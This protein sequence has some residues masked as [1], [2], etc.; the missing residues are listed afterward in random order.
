MRSCSSAR[1]P[2]VAISGS[3][4]R[5]IPSSLHAALCRPCSRYQDSSFFKKTLSPVWARYHPSALI[6][7]RGAWA[8][9]CAYKRQ[10]ICWALYLYHPRFRYHSQRASLLPSYRTRARAV[11][12]CNRSCFVLRYAQSTKS[13]HCRRFSHNLEYCFDYRFDY[14]FG[15]R[16]G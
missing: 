1:W 15:H 4:R 2:Y 11:H 6:Q 8:A 14:K 5:A 13:R 16:F 10:T 3:P 9:R 12:W 7:S